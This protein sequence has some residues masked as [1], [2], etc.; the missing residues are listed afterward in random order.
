MASKRRVHFL[1]FM[2]DVHQR[3]HRC[4]QRGISGEVMVSTVTDEILED[5]WL[6][7]FDE[8]QVPHG[9]AVLVHRKYIPAQQRRGSRFPSA[10]CILH[11]T[12]ASRMFER[13]RVYAVLR[14]FCR[15]P[16]SLLLP[17]VWCTRTSWKCRC[18][19]VLYW[20]CVGEGQPGC[21]YRMCRHQCPFVRENS[22]AETQVDEDVTSRVLHTYVPEGLKMQPRRY[23]IEHRII[24]CVLSYRR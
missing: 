18:Y 9:T 11:T 13:S 6:L 21:R 17:R 10:A 4:R 2:L 8:M 15:P 1:D 20:C 7:C 3:M 22:A 23:S 14:R 19:S 12:T 24:Y 5:G 16:P